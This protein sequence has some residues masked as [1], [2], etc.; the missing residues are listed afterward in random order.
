MAEEENINVCFT[1]ETLTTTICLFNSRV[2][3][4]VL[5]SYFLH[6]FRVNGSSPSS[7]VWFLHCRAHSS[8][9]T[10]MTSERCPLTRMR[11]TLSTLNLHSFLQLMEAP[12]VVNTNTKPISE[13]SWDKCDQNPMI[14]FLDICLLCVSISLKCMPIPPRF[15]PRSSP[16]S[17]PPRCSCFPTLRPSTWTWTRPLLWPG[18]CAVWLWCCLFI[19]GRTHAVWLVK[20]PSVGILFLY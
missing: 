19:G 12:L 17:W 8:F 13:N 18:G 6:S 2:C 16:T 1:G 5:V 7:Q 14:W 4:N 10:P 11:K 15:H 20:T 3:R 9:L